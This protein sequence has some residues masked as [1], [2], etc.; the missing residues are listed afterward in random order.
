MRRYEVEVRLVQPRDVVICSKVLL[1]VSEVSE[2]ASG[3]VLVRGTLGN[4]EAWERS[5]K[6]N[7]LVTHV[8]VQEALA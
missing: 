3:K 8:G 7:S 6:P 1:T 5:Y 2:E 4:G